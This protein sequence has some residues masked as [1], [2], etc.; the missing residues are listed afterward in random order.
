MKDKKEN[1]S[2]EKYD[3]WELLKNSPS[4]ILVIITFSVFFFSYIFNI[5]YFFLINDR[6]I[7]LLSLRDYF[8][9]TLPIIGVVGVV[10]I[11]NVSFQSRNEGIYS[12]FKRVK[13]DAREIKEECY[14]YGEYKGHVLY[15]LGIILL[16]VISIIQLVSVNI[17]H[18]LTGIFLY[19]SYKNSLQSPLL[20][21][22]YLA[23]LC[24]TVFVASVAADLFISSRPKKYKIRKAFMRLF[25]LV[26]VFSF[27]YGLYKSS[28]DISKKFDNIEIIHLDGKV[29]NSLFL[30]AIDKGVFHFNR[31]NGQVIF[32]NLS[33]IKT[34]Q[35]IEK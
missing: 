27:S 26:S 13:K 33:G 30:R 22:E 2:E 25:V 14:A 17:G 35:S 4:S 31:E 28:S 23:S 18:W 16:A 5:G 29:E 10:N 6:F 3:F 21:S 8:E 12:Y 1:R 24:L 19:V 34:I 9:G 32:S 15:L 11:L 7:S 20:N